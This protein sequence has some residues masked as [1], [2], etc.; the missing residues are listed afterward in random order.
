MRVGQGSDNKGQERKC[1]WIRLPRDPCARS[2]VHGW[3]RD[4]QTVSWGRK[5][6]EHGHFDLGV[7]GE[8]NGEVGAGRHR[9]RNWGGG[10]MITHS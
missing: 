6:G 4:W 8:G 10:G 2:W 9:C 3:N 7:H 5:H 1:K